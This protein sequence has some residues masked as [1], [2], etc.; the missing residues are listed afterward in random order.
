[1]RRK[2]I[3]AY[4]LVCYAVFF[5]TFLYMIGF[6]ANLAVP[7]SIDSGGTGDPLLALFV[8][9]TLLAL[10]AVQHSGMARRGFK[11]WLRSVVPPAAE[12]STFVL[13]S[14]LVLL[15]MVWQWRPLPG[16]VWAVAD[17]AGRELLW[18]LCALGWLTVLLGTFMISHTHLFGLAQ[19]RARLRGEPLPEPAFQTRWLYRYVRHPLMLGFLIAFWA[20]PDM[21]A[22]HLLFAAG[23]TGYILMAT[24]TLE[25][26]DLKRVLGEPYRRYRERVP[27]FIPRLGRGVRVEELTSKGEVLPAHE[28]PAS[29][30]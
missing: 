22:G 14:S 12:R 4:G 26:R 18:G 17:P 3:F 27:A 6:V 30:S 10:F 7:K 28:H 11:R 19:A 20:T 5:A 1:M 2:A 29:T 13:S 23:S 8:D 21:T 9:V 24:L 15:L 16:T 25:E